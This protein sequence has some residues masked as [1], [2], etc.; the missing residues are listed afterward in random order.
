MNK[1]SV[2]FTTSSSKLNDVTFT[3]LLSQLPE[4]YQKKIHMFR[5]W[6]DAQLALLGKTLLQKGLSDYGFNANSLNHIQF[7]R[8]GRPYLEEPIDF[9]ISHSG[10]YVLCAISQHG[11]VGIDVEQVKPLDLSHYRSVFTTKEWKSIIHASSPLTNFYMYWT[12]KEAI[13]KACGKGLST[14]LDQFEVLSSPV[15]MEQ[16]LWYYHHISLREDYRC[17]LATSQ[18]SVDIQLIPVHVAHVHSHKLP[19]FA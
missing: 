2:Y 9:N 5:R 16:K 14:P 7:S 17:H 12:I 19:G 18:P 10:N 11:R 3:H 1:V 8:E 13:I 4:F 15:E 6:E